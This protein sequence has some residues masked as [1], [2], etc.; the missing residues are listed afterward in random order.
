MFVIGKSMTSQNVSEQKQERKRM[1]R[2][3]TLQMYVVYR[4]YE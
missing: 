1:E 4:W 2:L 3:Y